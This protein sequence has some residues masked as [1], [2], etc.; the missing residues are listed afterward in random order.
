[1]RFTNN[2]EMKSKPLFHKQETRYTCV[3]ACLRMVFGAFGLEITE[4]ELRTRCNCTPFNGTTALQ[5]VDAARELG[6][7][8]TTKHNLSLEELRELIADGYFPIVFVNLRP[9]DGV[10]ESHAIVILSVGDQEVVVI[11]PLSG[12]R[13]LPLRVFDSAWTMALNLTILVEQ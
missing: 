6:F 13:T 5:A 2:T 8:G 4:S 9:I 1:M 10:T 3:P 11:D 7:T 12:E